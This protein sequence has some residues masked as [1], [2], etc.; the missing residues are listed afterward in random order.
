VLLY[1]LFFD[2]KYIWCQTKYKIAVI[3]LNLNDVAENSKNVWAGCV[4]LPIKVPKL[5]HYRNYIAVI[6][7]VK[8]KMLTN[9]AFAEPLY[10][11]SFYRFQRFSKNW[12]S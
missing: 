6:I 10:S 12:E 11:T 5:L 2:L 4:M 1:F 3:Q 9:F 7:S 8:V